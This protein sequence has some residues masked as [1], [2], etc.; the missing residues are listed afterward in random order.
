MF[1]NL[2]LYSSALIAH[3]IVEYMNEHYPWPCST[4]FGKNES[5]ICRFQF[6]WNAIRIRFGLLCFYYYCCY[7]YS[8]WTPANQTTIQSLIKTIYFRCDNNVHIVF[9]QQFTH[10]S[11]FFHI[12]DNI[13]STVDRISL[14]SNRKYIW[15]VW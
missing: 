4:I 7:N 12:H 3:I 5:F 11:I 10:F 13:N 6:V 8:N 14:Y 1:R 2:W 15:F 9:Y